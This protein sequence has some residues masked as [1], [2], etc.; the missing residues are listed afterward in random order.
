MIMNK[1]IKL[2]AAQNINEDAINNE[3]MHI[4]NE[5][6]SNT[7]ELSVVEKIKLHKRL[8][9]GIEITD[10]LSKE[11]K[12]KIVQK[13]ETDEYKDLKESIMDIENPEKYKTPTIS[14]EMVDVGLGLCVSAGVFFGIYTSMLAGGAEI[15]VVATVGT[16]AS[17]VLSSIGYGIVKGI[18]DALRENFDYAQQDRDIKSVANYRDLLNS[19]IKPET[20]N[21]SIIRKDSDVNHHA[22]TTMNIGSRP[23]TKKNDDKKGNNIGGNRI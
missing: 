16:L 6:K 12:D 10:G 21:V 15:A 9:S 11:V 5:D 7:V 8:Y 23:N 17:L 13:L 22:S 14:P 18:A 19:S 1:L 2:A 20:E 4:D 3:F